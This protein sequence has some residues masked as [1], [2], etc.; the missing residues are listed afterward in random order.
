M[1]DAISHATRDRSMNFEEIKANAREIELKGD[2][3]KRTSGATRST[4]KRMTIMS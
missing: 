2:G 4:G 1:I 3:A